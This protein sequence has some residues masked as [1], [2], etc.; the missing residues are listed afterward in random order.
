M[1][2]SRRLL[3]A[4]T[5][6]ASVL[7]ATA[8]CRENQAPAIGKGA[9]VRDSSEQSYFGGRFFLLD[10]TT[11]R[12]RL[13]ADTILS[14]AGGTRYEMRQVHG[15]FFDSLGNE[16]ATLVAREATVLQAEKQVEARGAVVV[17]TPDHGRLMTDELRYNQATDR[18]TSNAQFEYV[19][20]ERHGRGAGFETNSRMTTF[21]CHSPCTG[22]FP[23]PLR[24]GRRG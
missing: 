15:V 20:D 13:N 7:S 10:S 16:V 12:A 3:V 14:Y 18:I 22:Q 6:A 1:T 17:E 5:A 19:H 8:G 24:S 23:E 11:V 21:T 4:A 9:V 2:L